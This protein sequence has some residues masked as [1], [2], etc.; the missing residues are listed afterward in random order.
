VIIGSEAIITFEDSIKGKPLNLYSKKIDIENGIPEK[1]DVPVD[2][3]EYSARL[4]LTN[5][6]S[7]FVDHLNGNKQKN[8][9]VNMLWM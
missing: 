7:Y 4:P 1:I 2:L 3:I 8:R 6:L 5:E 9:M